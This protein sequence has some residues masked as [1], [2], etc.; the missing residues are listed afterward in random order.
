MDPCA[1][2][3]LFTKNVPHILEKIFFSLDYESFTRC[4][5]VCNAWSELLSSESFRRKGKSLYHKTYRRKFWLAAQRGNV[6]EV[7]RL[8]YHGVEDVNIVELGPRCST[9]LHEAAWSG[10]EE[11]VKVL[12]ESGANIELADNKG[13]LP[14]YYALARG[15]KNVV[16]LLLNKSRQP[17]NKNV[18]QLLLNKAR[19]PARIK[20]WWGLQRCDA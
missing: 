19:Q 4:M 10:H 5:K 7:R 11:M 20:A 9:P 6:K 13:E 3:K 1:F 14:L 12:L 18:V 8:L 16:K 17:A 15:H 2:D